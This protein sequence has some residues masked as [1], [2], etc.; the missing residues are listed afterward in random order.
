M[1]MA[2]EAKSGFRNESSDM[3]GITK[4]GITHDCT[5]GDGTSTTI[6]SDRL[7]FFHFAYHLYFSHH[8][9]IL[10]P[11]V[12]TGRN[13]LLA[14]AEGI[15]SWSSCATCLP[16]SCRKR[17]EERFL[18]QRVLDWNVALVAVLDPRLEPFDSSS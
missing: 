4:L 12:K 13:P 7:Y 17:W 18:Y 1:I 14:K 8:C 9:T 6:E 2:A 3:Y 16:C 10:P 5:A 15:T 11:F